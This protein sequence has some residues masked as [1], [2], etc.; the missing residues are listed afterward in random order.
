MDG[1]QNNF[2]NHK[3]LFY[4][5]W[6][7]AAVFFCLGAVAGFFLRQPKTTLDLFP[8]LSNRE[9][10]EG[11]GEFTNPLLE[12]DLAEEVFTELR[13]FKNKVEDFVKQTQATSNNVDFVSVYFRDLSNGPWF[14]I[15]E[16]ENF[17][18]ASLL[19]V[20]LMIAYF[21]Q[22]E[23]NPEILQKSFSFEDDGTLPLAQQTILPSQTLE[24]GK[25]YTVEDLLYR[26]IV[27]SD[28]KAQHLVVK[29]MDVDTF[30]KVYSDFGLSIPSQNTPETL[31]SVK[32]YASFFR[33]L[34][35]ASYL[36]KFYSEKALKL[37]SQVE[38]KD[39]LVA[40]V[41]AAIKVAHKFGERQ[42]IGQ[43]QKQLHDCGIVYYPKHPY[44]LC[45]MSRG[46]SIPDQA[47]V[48]RDLSKL[49][50]Q[51]VDKQFGK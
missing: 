27:Y 32:N 1:N 13:P 19:K 44:L 34:F 18:P 30:S 9:V 29:N 23:K 49:I 36:S 3:R 5:P 47:Q 28:N 8:I 12:C 14:G 6:L 10:R 20:P 26:M 17:T 16:K 31:V 39:A 35:N 25:V 21:K 40:G 46:D 4:S 38:Y 22:A 51:E 50:Y 2:P 11:G 43:S 33:M 24:V 7:L 37:L 48:I 41:P 45:L 42:N 15:N